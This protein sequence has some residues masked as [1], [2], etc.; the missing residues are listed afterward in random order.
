[1]TVQSMPLIFIINFQYQTQNE[2]PGCSCPSLSINPSCVPYQ[3]YQ[4]VVPCHSTKKRKQEP[5]RLKNLTLLRLVV[6]H[7]YDP[8]T[9][10][11]YAGGSQAGDFQLYNDINVHLPNRSAF[12]FEYNIQLLYSF[13]FLFSL[14]GSPS[15]CSETPS[16]CPDTSSR[17]NVDR[18]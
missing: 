10:K 7:T 14:P 11:P 13:P 5:Q 8:S 16:M 9:W 2:L 17:L 1:M 6:A 4:W 15:E 12:H 3:V 18:S